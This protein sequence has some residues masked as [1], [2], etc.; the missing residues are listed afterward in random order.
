M[1]KRIL[2]STKFFM[3]SLLLILVISFL[4]GCSSDQSKQTI[5]ITEIQQTQK[6]AL[7]TGY[8]FKLE[9]VDQLIS[10]SDINRSGYV[11]IIPISPNNN[12]NKSKLLQEKFYA[13]QIVA[14]HI[15]DLNDST[16]KRSDMLTIENAKVICFIGNN[17][18]EFLAFT[19]KTGLRD[20]IHV[21]YN[22]GCL[23]AG[24]G[25]C[26]SIFGST[27][28]VSETNITEN[29]KHV[30]VTGLD[31]FTNTIIYNTNDQSNI[32]DGVISKSE[33]TNINYIGIDNSSTLLI[34]N[35][36]IVNVIDG[37]INYLSNNTPNYFAAGSTFDLLPAK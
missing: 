30:L 37:S 20:V 12:N 3:K 1:N 34:Q 18:D 22:K 5:E 11:V 19:S 16:L 6:T 21:A 26:A 31:L 10:K 9:K 8:D 13:K 15:L 2:N 29:K 7:L 25:K 28:I 24:F 17:V 14:V 27:Y 4:Y 35:S 23:I 36:K 32:I 33:N